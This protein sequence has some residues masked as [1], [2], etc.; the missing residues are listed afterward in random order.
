L[1]ED[2]RPSRKT[3]ET[4]V[5]REKEV[6]IEGGEDGEGQGG[7]RQGGEADGQ[8]SE[9]GRRKEKIADRQSERASERER[10]RE[11]PSE[12]GV[13]AGPARIIPLRSREGWR[14]RRAA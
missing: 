8:D 13:S 2:P 6:K 5:E 4:G 7:E 3:G 12:A 9:E 10:A 1:D 11:S 14:V